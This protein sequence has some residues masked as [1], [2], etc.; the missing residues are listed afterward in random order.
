MIGR[1]LSQAPAV[2]GKA[3][4]DPGGVLI[5]VLVLIGLVLLLGGAV[6]WLRAKLLSRDRQRGGDEGMLES[7]RRLRDRGLMSEEE[8]ARTRELV[9]RRLRES[10]GAEGRAEGPDEKR[11]RGVGGR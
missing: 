10:L 4:P 6:L 7:M 5:W 2:A 8:F 1:V 9:R 11:G 3:R